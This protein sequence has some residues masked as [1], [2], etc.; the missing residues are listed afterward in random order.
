[1][2]DDE[3]IAEFI[4]K[5]GVTRCP[6]GSGFVW[7]PHLSRMQKVLLEGNKRSRN[8]VPGGRYYRPTSKYSS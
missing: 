6:P 2:T 4:K 3:K 7:S 1:M 8:R 5:R